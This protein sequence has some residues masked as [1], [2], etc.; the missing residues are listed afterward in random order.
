MNDVLPFLIRH[1]YAVLFLSVLLE[2]LGLPLPSTPVIIA[3][4]ALAHTGQMN[5]AVAI[6]LATVAS[7]LADLS[8]YQIGRL[9]GV[10]VLRLLCRISLEPDYCVRRTEN[11]FSR[12]GAKSL[13]VAKFVPGISAV[14][15]PV[16]GINHLPLARFLIYDGTGALLW[17]GTFVLLG[18]LF[19]NQLEQVIDYTE[20][21]GS[22][23]VVVLIALVLAWI[24][25][26]YFQRRRFLRSLRIARILPE[27]LKSM[28]DR[29]DQVFV[30]DLRHVIDLEDEPRTIPGALRLPAEEFEQR[31]NELPRDRELV[32][33]CT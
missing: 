20:R 22:L 27:Q 2:Q 30:V 5:L 4:G 6:L 8:W 26:K 18:Y 1:G 12:H 13:L 11:V 14:A 25:W 24:G 16:A 23:A 21:F 32:L 17:I 29:G 15:P 10:K 3:A 7:V 9:R 33:F 28:M 19:S 31:A